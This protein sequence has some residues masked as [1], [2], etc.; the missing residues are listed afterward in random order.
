MKYFHVNAESVAWR[1]GVSHSFC[2][3]APDYYTLYMV[4]NNLQLVLAGEDAMM[5]YT[6]EDDED[7][8]EANLC[9]LVATEWEYDDPDTQNWAEN[10][11]IKD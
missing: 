10:F 4:E 2:V 7:N 3:K 5:G 9:T 11:E 1:S 8:D 6:E